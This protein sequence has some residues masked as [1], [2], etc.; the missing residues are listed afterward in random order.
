ME[1][2][3]QGVCHALLWLEHDDD[4]RAKIDE[5]FRVVSRRLR[6]VVRV[7]E[8]REIETRIGSRS[9]ETL[10][11][12]ATEGGAREWCAIADARGP[13]AL[14]GPVASCAIAT[15]EALALQRV[16]EAESADAMHADGSCDLG[17]RGRARHPFH[18][19]QHGEPP[20]QRARPSHVA[21]FRNHQHPPY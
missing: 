9:L 11:N 8:R 12:R 18:V 13:L 10:D 5:Q 17:R 20:G 14:D 16:Q 3:G 1:H 7:V 4:S 19:T 2:V 6:I 15:Q 21:R